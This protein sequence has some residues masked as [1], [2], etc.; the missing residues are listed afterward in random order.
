MK[1]NENEN[2]DIS[3]YISALMGTFKPTNDANQAT[4]WFTTSE[5]YQAIKSIDPSAK[6]SINDVFE[7]MNNAGFHFQNRPGSSGCD[8]RWM[9]KLKE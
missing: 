4:H 1:K 7:G 2:T 3:V 8:F 9:L 6:A 5:V